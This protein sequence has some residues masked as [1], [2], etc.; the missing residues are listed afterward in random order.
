MCVKCFEGELCGKV[1]EHLAATASA[2]SDVAGAGNVVGYVEQAL[3]R[4]A[5]LYIYPGKNPA[6]YSLSINGRAES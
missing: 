3:W 5:Y 2:L 4:G 6:F 1:L